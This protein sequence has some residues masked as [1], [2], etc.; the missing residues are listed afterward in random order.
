MEKRTSEKFH[1]GRKGG[2]KPSF[3]PPTII[4]FCKVISAR[5]G[6]KGRGK[7]SFF[8]EHLTLSV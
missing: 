4:Q 7:K 1:I 8:I 6:I 2:I 3:S 5:E